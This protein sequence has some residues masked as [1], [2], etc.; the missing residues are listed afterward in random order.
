MPFPFPYGARDV[1]GW[2]SFRR[3]QRFFLR[4]LLIF[5]LLLFA[6]PLVGNVPQPLHRIGTFLLPA[7]MV[8]WVIFS[9]YFVTANASSQSK[10]LCPRCGK[11][12]FGLFMWNPYK[13]R[14]CGIEIWT[15]LVSADQIGVH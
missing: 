14:H 2:E 10:L 4:N 7:F 3:H 15:S 8:V 1:A 13:C 6:M 5:V 12:F 9:L 11:Q